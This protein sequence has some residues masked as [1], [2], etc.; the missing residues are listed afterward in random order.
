MKKIIPLFVLLFVGLFSVSSD[1][2]QQPLDA[3][4]GPINEVISILKDPKYED[5]SQKDLERE[6]LWAA[7]RK[8][9]DFTEMAKRSLARNWKAFAPEQRKEFS[10]VFGEFLGNAYLNKI[11]KDYQDEEVVYGKQ[12]ILTDTKAVVKTKIIRETV[13]IPVDYSMKARNGAWRVYDVNI[14]GVSMIKNYR[15][16]FNKILATKS[17]TELIERLKKKIEKQK[18]GQDKSNQA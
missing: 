1:C 15:T 16:Q 6:Q 8:L 2:G 10:E 17:P 3:L 14:E 13:E 7:M 9:F 11:Q 5:A 4:R 12:E 18:Q